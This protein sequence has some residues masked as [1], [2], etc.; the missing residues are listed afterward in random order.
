MR[1][2]TAIQ[3]VSYRRV[4]GSSRLFDRPGVPDLNFDGD[5]MV[6]WRFLKDCR[7]L[8]SSKYNDC[9]RLWI[10]NEGLGWQSRDRGII[11]DWE[12]QA[13]ERG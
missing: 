3:V 7:R 6:H 4:V 11:P 10:G 8:R 5:D 13:S 12:Q 2:G 9:L 1:D